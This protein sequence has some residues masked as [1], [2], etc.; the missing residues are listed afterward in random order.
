VILLALFQMLKPHLQVPPEQ[1][2]LD[3][4][5]LDLDGVTTIL[6]KSTRRIAQKGHDIPKLGAILA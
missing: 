2:I 3:K 1:L 6:Q 5:G 4:G